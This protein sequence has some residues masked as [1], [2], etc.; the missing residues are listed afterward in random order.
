MYSS[1]DMIPIDR[2]FVTIYRAISCLYV[3]TYMR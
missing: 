1:D 3:P 2:D